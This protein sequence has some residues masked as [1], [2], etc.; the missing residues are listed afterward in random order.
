MVLLTTVMTHAQ[1]NRSLG[2]AVG[3]VTIDGKV[4]NQVALRP[5]IPIWK[6]GI[7]LD[8]VLYL[9]DEGNIHRDEWDFSSPG[10]TKNT[11]LDKIYYIRYGNP[12][13][14]LY[15]KVGA[16]DNVTL[17]Y[18]ILVSDYSNT[19]LYPDFRKIGLETKVNSKKFRVSGFTN[20]LKENAGLS[21]VRVETN[22]F[23][24]IP[25]AFTAV[26]DRNQYF[27]LKD[28]D[29]DGRPDKLDDF[30]ENKKFWLDSDGDG[31][32]DGD[33]AEIDRDGDGLPDVD[34]LPVINA[35]WRDLEAQVGYDF[36]DD[37]LVN[38]NP[39]SY[40]DLAPEPL[41][42]KKELDPVGAV[43]I[44][45]GIPIL[46]EDNMS[47]AFYSQ[48]A[49]LIGKTINPESGKNV[50]LGIG[51][52]PLGLNMKFGPGRFNL[53]YRIIPSGNF[54]FNFWDE[55][56]DIQRASYL[57]NA[58]A[59]TVRT[60]E[61][62]LG[63]FGKQKGFYSRFVIGMGSWID[64]SAT[65]QNM[66]GMIWKPSKNIFAE[67]M[68]QNFLARAALT[69][70]VSKLHRA[71]AFYQQ[72]NTPNPFKF[73]FNENTLLG[74]KIGLELGSGLVIYYKYYRTFRDIN[75]DGDVRDDGE[76]FNV[77]TIETSFIL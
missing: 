14:R 34:S 25:I 62:S 54:E 7:A 28:R 47:L 42:V 63:V 43:A 39:D 12:T 18:G 46:V 68:N 74:Y 61:S 19:L 75:G 17:G 76:T 1:E 23:F 15:L 3:T 38:I 55:M 49:G 32:A 59:L 67:E 58:G 6:F 51:L 48:A 40:P 37:V 5:V 10:K 56:Y 36:L 45:I 70:P 72:K 64:L 26:L 8:L 11:I 24:D 20:D 41:N 4:W 50:N 71:E 2:G 52:V 53:E 73:K 30:P 69:K 13:D 33:P 27:G 29:G 77:T 65:Y 21:G 57:D 16:L 22:K 60:K 35:F 9:D 44:D 66:Q 31:L